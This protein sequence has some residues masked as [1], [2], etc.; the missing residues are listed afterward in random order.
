MACEGEPAELVGT[1][2]QR[3]RKE[4][5]KVWSMECRKIARSPQMRA[6]RRFAYLLKG[7]TAGDIVALRQHKLMVQRVY[8]Y[9]YK[10]KSVFTSAAPWPIIWLLARTAPKH[11]Y[12]GKQDLP[13]KKLRRDILNFAHRIGWKF[14]KRKETWKPPFK[15][16]KPK[17]VG[18]QRATLEVPMISWLTKLKNTCMEAIEEANRSAKRRRESNM[19]PLAAYA[20][21]LMKRGS[22]KAL[23]N[24]KGGGYSLIDARDLENIE[25]RVLED[26]MYMYLDLGTYT[27]YVRAATANGA[28]AI[29]L[30]G[31]KTKDMDLKDYLM[32]P[33]NR[34]G[35]TSTATLHLKVKA[36]KANPNVSC[37]A[38]H[39][40]PNY[41]LEGLS[42][43]LAME[44]RGVL[45][46]SCSWLIK[47]SAEAADRLR[48]VRLNDKHWLVKIDVKDFFYSGS[49][50]QLTEDVLKIWETSNI[51]PARRAALEALLNHQ[52]VRGRR[53]PE[54]GAYLLTKGT[55]MG[56]PHSGEVADAAYWQ[57]CEKWFTKPEVA[58]KLGIALYMRFKDDSLLLV[59]K[60]QLQ[61]LLTHVRLHAGY[62]ILEVESVHQYKARFLELDL[63]RTGDRIKIAYGFKPSAVPQP[64]SLLSGHAKNV[65]SSWPRMM[66]RSI[67]RVSANKIEAENKIGELKARYSRSLVP[68]LWPR[69]EPTPVERDR[70]NKKEERKG[71]LWLPVSMY[72]ALQRVLPQKIR[73]FDLANRHLM[74]RAFENIPGEQ[75]SLNIA[76]RTSVPRLEYRVR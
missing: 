62:F 74:A 52:M 26:P 48:S 16:K 72:P 1:P 40:L 60:Q 67:Q 38:L 6:K 63:E 15:L 42:K 17:E 32:R 2:W 43:W 53:W 22:M 58:K 29:K 24:D 10:E 61:K 21:A 13:L 5:R 4:R 36:T 19:P 44:I 23:T 33:L 68:V 51:T 39:T 34:S 70:S 27:S 49:T 7:L 73:E 64:L 30:I 9:H 75:T 37:R 35:Q 28:R 31:E 45:S 65:H 14:E 25:R 3:K 66:V 69:N 18:E 57:K 41:E 47:N 56:L 20:L 54:E 11:L 76:W 59:E 46:Q 8:D 71:T 50:Q 12:F 55:G